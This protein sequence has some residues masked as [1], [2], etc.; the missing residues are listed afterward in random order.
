MV[1]IC[2][3]VM[4]MRKHSSEAWAGMKASFSKWKMLARHP[5]EHLEEAQGRYFSQRLSLLLWKLKWVFSSI[6]SSCPSLFGEKIYVKIVPISLLMKVMRLKKIKINWR[7]LF[8][9]KWLKQLEDAIL[10]CLKCC[11]LAHPENDRSMNA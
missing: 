4:F 10:L 9:N 11:Y 5:G 2:L 6:L 8:F 3:E 1:A 7:I